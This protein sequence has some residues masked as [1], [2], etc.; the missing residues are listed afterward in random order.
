MKHRTETKVILTAIAAVTAS[1]SYRSS[2]RDAVALAQ[3]VARPNILV[4]MTDDQDTQSM[5][6]L[7]SVEEHIG[8]H[9]T[10]FLNSFAVQPVC[11]PSR[12]TFLTGQYSHNH[13]VTHNAYGYTAL[14]HNETLAVWL[15]AAGYHT[16]HVG[17]YLN[18]YN[19][20]TLGVPEVAPEIPA[21]WDEWYATI[22]KNGTQGPGAAQQ[23]YYHYFLYEKG[24]SGPPSPT[25]HAGAPPDYKTDVLTDKAV[26]FLQRWTANPSPFFLAVAY[27]APHGGKPGLETYGAREPWPA[28]RHFGVGYGCTSNEALVL[29]P[30]PRPPSFDEADEADKPEFVRAGLPISG[31]NIPK[32]E[33]NH[34]LRAMTLLSVNDGVHRIMEALKATGKLDNTVV[35]FTS[36]NGFMLGEHGLV[37]KIHAYEESIRVPLV[38]R[39]PGG[40][41]NRTASA[42]VGNLDLAPTI[43]DV[44]GVT[45]PPGVVLDGRSL[46]PLLAGTPTAWRSALLLESYDIRGV[47]PVAERSYA[48]VRTALHTYVEYYPSGE[49]E[50]YGNR[51]DPFQLVSR[52][53]S[54][55]PADQA[56]KADLQARLG[57]LKDCV[58]NSG[59]PPPGRFLCWE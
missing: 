56:A 19:G 9:G 17:K 52:H 49:Q 48:G 41:E 5:R 44:A 59:T 26:A 1:W 40:P 43:L 2:F 45:P 32:I 50:L 27:N 51:Q 16:V 13:G 47:P 34:R 6:F 42:L 54:T 21:G 36:D 58:G 3:P 23:F 18:G 25:S 10:T 33:R 30:L 35:I 57:R 29:L 22:D 46:V 39:T 12:A 53:A 38:I 4:I 37:G 15:D 7:P 8:R 20:T 11:A 31:D 55:D 14:D 28:P 24:P